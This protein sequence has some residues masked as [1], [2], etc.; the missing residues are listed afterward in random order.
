MTSVRDEAVGLRT[1]LGWY[2]YGVVGAK[3]A[4]AR[5]ATGVS[6]DAAHEVGLVTEGPLAGVV[7]AVSLEE[8][9]EAALPDRLGDASWL[10]QKIR[11]HEQVLERVLKQAS[12][13]PCR[14]CTVYRSEE[15]LRRF[16]SERREAL[17]EALER[18]QGQIEVG[19]KA[20]VDRERFAA[21]QARRNEAIRALDERLS[22]ADEGR[23]YLEGRRREQ[24]VSSELER[25]GAE[26]AEE[27]HSRLLAAAE[28]GISLQ[29]QS[30]EIS[31]RAGEM[32]FNGAY[33]VPADGTDFRE[34]LAALAEDYRD[35]G[36]ELELT[37]PWPPYNFVPTELSTS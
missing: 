22:A 7:S 18:M 11:A 1:G 2:L 24:L 37:G 31:G 6:V 27:L 14:F 36:A 28:D 19:V 13:V 20:F 29:L 10:E 8:F 4:P 3:E 5:F 30:P 15:E 25:F 12:V 26:L 34:E 33:L 9:D 21:E 23:A 32:V 17:E 16:L 35:A